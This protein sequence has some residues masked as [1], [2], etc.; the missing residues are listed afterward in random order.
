MKKFLKFT[1]L[2]L[3]VLVSFSVMCGCSLFANN[4]TNGSNKQ[5]G[6]GFTQSTI[7][8]YDGDQST[9]CVA[10][11]GQTA[12]ITVPIKKGYY[13]EGYFD[14]QE[15]G[16]KY[17]DAKGDS[18]LKWE[19]TFPS[20]FYARWGD[21]STLEQKITVFGN[22]PKSGSYSGQ[23]TAEVKLNDEFISALKSNFDG[24]LKIEYSID[25]ATAKGWD[26]A[27]Y[28]TAS[29]IGMYIKGYDN[30][31]AERH[32]I[33]IHTPEIETYTT[34]KG[35]AEIDATDFVNGN[36]YIVVWNTKSHMGSYAYPVFYS[37]NLTLSISFV[38]ENK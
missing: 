16:T 27:G 13:L 9:Q 11:Y 1:A 30:S 21:I 10:Q 23:R 37:R 20:V 3:V 24:K 29:P 31:G 5:V 2:T 17:F 38:E 28:D 22:E 36:M 34:F 26:T 8:L 14:A 12:T 18:L 32:T 35:S 6:E 25:L 15:G 4:S 7:T 33:F 19:K